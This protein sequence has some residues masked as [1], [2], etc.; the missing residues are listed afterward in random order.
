M[1]RIAAVGTAVPEHVISQEAVQAFS[2]DHFSGSL[3]GLHRLLSVFDRAAIARRYFAMKPDWLAGAHSF[4]ERNA[5]FVEEAT[6]LAAS[7]AESCL[8]RAGLDPMEVGTLLVVST[9]GIATPS[10]DAYLIERLGMS[11]HTRR[12]PIWGL[13]CAG[14]VAGLARAAELARSEPSGFVMLVAVELCGITFCPED[15][16]KSNFIATA[17]FGDGA[18]AVLV[19]G[20]E[21]EAS[22]PRLLGAHS[23]LWPKTYDVMGW[24]VADD[25][26][27][28]RFSREIPAFVRRYVR[29]AVE[30][31]LKPY[32]LGPSD[33][34]HHILHPGGPKVLGAYAEAL[35]LA[36]ELLVI[37]KAVLRD[38]GNMSSASVLFVLDRV[39]AESQATA[40][41]YGLLFALGP[42]FSAEQLLIRWEED[43]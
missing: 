10:I 41:D 25:G 6:N 40:G 39:L 22:G 12:L 31:F 24:D 43:A 2:R 7:A 18:G 1:A 28:V 9:T 13:G 15:R 38:Y 37:P 29:P 42:G 14:G 3:D 19:A 30:G 35:E 16:S 20:E 21:A 8:E 32:G 4:A 26:F 36:S 11:P 33:V 27:R 17:L 23:T 5:R 34:A